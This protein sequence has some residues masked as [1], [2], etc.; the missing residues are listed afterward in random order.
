MLAGG[1]HPE[2]V[3][4]A[5]AH[6]RPA[7]VDAHTG[8]EGPDGRKDTERVRAFVMEALSAFSDLCNDELF[9]QGFKGRLK[10]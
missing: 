6:V 5:I 9:S 7:G 2:N 10:P 8:V 1:L 3:R 4:R